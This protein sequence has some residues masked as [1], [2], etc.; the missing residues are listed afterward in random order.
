MNESR[1]EEPIF[2]FL[3]NTAKSVLNS[4]HLSLVRDLVRV[5]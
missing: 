5:L 1:T 3:K 4:K 2:L